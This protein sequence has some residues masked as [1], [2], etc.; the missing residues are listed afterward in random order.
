[1]AAFD[2]RLPS[3]E[4]DPVIGCVLIGRFY[5]RLFLWKYAGKLDFSGCIRMWHIVQGARRT[6]YSDRRY[7]MF[8]YLLGTGNYYGGPYS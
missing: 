2:R 8:W 3:M 4:N 6:M 7:I 5:L 1:M